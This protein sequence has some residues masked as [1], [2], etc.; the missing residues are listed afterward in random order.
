MLKKQQKKLLEH[1]FK[2]VITSEKGGS[3][4]SWRDR[5]LV[6][7]IILHLSKNWKQ[8]C[9]LQRQTPCVLNNSLSLCDLGQVNLPVCL[10]FLI[11]KMVILLLPAV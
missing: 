8:I 7:A 4:K 9:L 6:F 10:R 5:V 11:C 3:K 2:T 1:Y